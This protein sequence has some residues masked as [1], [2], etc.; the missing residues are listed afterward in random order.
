M[1]ITGFGLQLS[2]LLVQLTPSGPDF[3]TDGSDG[4]ESSILTIGMLTLATLILLLLPR[5][6]AEESRTSQAPR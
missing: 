5:R 3:R 1:L 4:P 6:W 2:A